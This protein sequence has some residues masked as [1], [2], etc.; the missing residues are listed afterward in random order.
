MRHLCVVDS[1]NLLV[2]MLTRKDLMTYKLEEN[3]ME[4]K[5][6]AIMRGYVYRWRARKQKRGDLAGALAKA[7]GNQAEARVNQVRAVA[8]TLDMHQ[9]RVLRV[10]VH[11]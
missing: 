1:N 6:E 5:A 8:G 7:R 3:V 2:G 9:L 10:G 11:G 4:H